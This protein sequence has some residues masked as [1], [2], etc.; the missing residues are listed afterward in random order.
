MI[1]SLFTRD[2]PVNAV[3]AA[4][5]TDIFTRLLNRQSSIAEM[6]YNHHTSP[7]LHEVLSPSLV[8]IAQNSDGVNIKINYPATIRFLDLKKANNGKKKRY[9]TPIY[10]RP[11]FG[12]IY[13]KGYSL[14]AAINIALNQAYSNYSGNLKNVIKNEL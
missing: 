12:H 2:T 9:Y 14:S 11:L 13:G 4:A 1:T 8:D 10:N 5:A 3:V 7:H 6:D